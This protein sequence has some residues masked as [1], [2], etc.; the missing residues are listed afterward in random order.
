MTRRRARTS[1]TSPIRPQTIAPALAVAE[2]QRLLQQ[3]V[4]SSCFWDELEGDS[5]MGEIFNSTC[6][7]GGGQQ[8]M[9]KPYSQDLRNRVIDA[10][11]TGE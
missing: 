4:R 1:N 7:L 5:R 11:R 10:V 2:T 8:E 6:W 9:A 3:P